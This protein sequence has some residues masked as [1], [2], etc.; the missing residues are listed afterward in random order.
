MLE[1]Q[2]WI[3]WKDDFNTGYKRI[4]DQHKELVSIINDLYDSANDK[5]IETAKVKESFKKAI[6]RTIDYASYHFSYEEKIMHAMD[7]SRTKDHI[8]RHRSFSNEVIDQV[9]LYEQGSRFV[10][11]QFVRYLRDWLLNHIVVEDKVFIGEI[12]EKLK[13]MEDKNNTNL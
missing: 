8:S 10:A 13:K 2:R 1:K 9:S 4:D 11:N 3:V 12:R 5:D 6:K 7:Y